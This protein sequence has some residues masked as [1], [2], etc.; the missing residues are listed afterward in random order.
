MKKWLNFV[1]YLPLTRF[2]KKAIQFVKDSGTLS[3]IHDIFTYDMKR[4]NASKRKKREIEK[5][6]KERGKKGGELY[7]L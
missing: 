6:K 1:S 2:E 4:R 3:S 5:N 7:S